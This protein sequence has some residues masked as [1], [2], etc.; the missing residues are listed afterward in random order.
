MYVHASI[1]FK[2]SYNMCHFIKNI[3]VLLYAYTYLC[4]EECV[5][6]LGTVI[7]WGFSALENRQG[8]SSYFV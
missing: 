3:S 8:F 2:S 6:R 4:I 5:L 1:P 7:T